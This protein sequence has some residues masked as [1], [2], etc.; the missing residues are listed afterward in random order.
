MHEQNTDTGT[1]SET[2]ILGDGV[3][4]SNNFTLF[5]SD[6]TGSPAIRYNGSLKVWQYSNDGDNFANFGA[7]DGTY[8]PLAGGTMTGD[9]VFA[10]TQTF[11]ASKITGTLGLGQGGTGLSDGDLSSG[12]LLY[13]SSGDSFS[14]IP[15]G[16]V[17][18]VLTITSGGIPAWR[19]S[20]AISPHDILSVHHSDTI[21]GVIQPGDLIIAVDDSGETKWSRLAAGKQWPISSNERWGTH[22]EFRQCFNSA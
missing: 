8:L 11:S 14:R 3:G 4:L 10:D 21:P 6:D 2:F 22:L 19:S 12:D 13:Y 1:D 18:Q 20:T 7:A 9:I 16:S 5:V 17:G 15:L